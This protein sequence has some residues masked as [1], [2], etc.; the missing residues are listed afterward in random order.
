MQDGGTE[1][2]QSSTNVACIV[3]KYNVAES[4]ISLSSP[5]EGARIAATGSDNGYTEFRAACVSNGTCGT[6]TMTAGQGQINASSPVAWQIESYNDSI[7]YLVTGKNAAI[8]PLG[9]FADGF[10]DSRFIE[11]INSAPVLTLSSTDDAKN[12]NGYSL[13]GQSVP[14]Y[15]NHIYV[16]ASGDQS[17]DTPQSFYYDWIFIKSVD[18]TG[19]CSVSLEMLVSRNLDERTR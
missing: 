6:L 2:S 11:Q 17:T 1:I 15:A 5:N 18:C 19:N 14:I 10:A 9:Y 4:T 3:P 7:A 8:R 12:P 16:L 13:E